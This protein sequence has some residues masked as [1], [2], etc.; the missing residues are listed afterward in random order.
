MKKSLVRNKSF[1]LVMFGN[2]VSLLGDNMQRFALSLYVLTITHSAVKFSQVLMLAAIPQALLLP[3]AGVFADIKDRKAIMVICDL[4]SGGI[5][6][7]FSIFFIIHGRVPIAAIYF[8][9]F[10]LSITSAFEDPAANSV[11]PSIV[12]EEQYIKAASINSTLNS[13]NNIITPTISATL[14]G[15]FGILPLTIIN[16]ISF[17]ISAICEAIAD[18][19]KIKDTGRITPAKFFESLLGGVR[20]V[21]ENSFIKALIFM[22]LALNFSV[23]AITIGVPIITIELFKGS[24]LQLGIVNSFAS[25]AMLLS[26]FFIKTIAKNKKAQHLIILLSSLIILYF[27]LFAIITL[28]AIKGMINNKLS[29]IILLTLIYFLY[30]GT[31]VS[32]NILVSATIP[33][34]CPMEKMGRV[35]ALITMSAYTTSLIGKLLFGYSYA[36]LPAFG[37][38][39]IGIVF[40]M[41]STLFISYPML[42]SKDVYVT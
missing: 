34:I 10:V 13:I 20:F 16:S 21:K 28:P 31:A 26:P 37:N 39:L 38:M 23:C 6:C 7:F 4:I 41:I 30:M 29:S 25:A 11:I 9:V 3:F 17:F 36:Y 2:T 22:I 24:T 12:E 32:V 40:T 8:L 27:G 19:P 1:V 18:I 5:T 14:F 15:F 33:K 42:R 35:D